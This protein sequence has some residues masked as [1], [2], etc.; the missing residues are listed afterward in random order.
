MK[1]LTRRNVR[2]KL[3]DEALKTPYSAMQDI[4]SMFKNV[5]EIPIIE[6]AGSHPY[7]T[8][9]RVRTPFEITDE[10]HPI[11]HHEPKHG[12]SEE[13]IR[14]FEGPELV[15]ELAKRG[16]VQ[17]EHSLGGIVSPYP[18]ADSSDNWTST[19]SGY[20]ILMSE[21][22]IKSP[23]QYLIAGEENCKKQLELWNVKHLSI[24]A[25]L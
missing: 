17:I 7:L 4:F 10:A 3:I 15:A 13:Q 6:T 1:I 5:G 24:D 2:I 19:V 14:K 23:M 25:L 9:Y 8:L 21:K 22:F 20:L 18:T 16:K 11:Y 12:L